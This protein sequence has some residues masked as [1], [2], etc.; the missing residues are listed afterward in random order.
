MI[1]ILSGEVDRTTTN[2]ILNCQ[3]KKMKIIVVNN[4]KIK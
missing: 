2:N 1:G 4:N 3:L